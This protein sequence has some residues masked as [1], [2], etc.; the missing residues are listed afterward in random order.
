[1]GYKSVSARDICEI[2][3]SEGG[4]FRVGPSNTANRIIPRPTL[5]A[6]ATKFETKRV[7]IQIL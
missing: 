7:I 2:F 4:G 6:M 3:A 1:M 5:V